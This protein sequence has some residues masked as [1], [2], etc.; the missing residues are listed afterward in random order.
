[1][2]V[3]AAYSA[4]TRTHA[5]QAT[6]VM[7]RSTSCNGSTAP[8]TGCM[9]RPPPGLAVPMSTPD[10]KAT[11]WALRTGENKLTEDKR[12]L[13]NH[14]ARTN[15]R[16]GRAW[17]LK[18]QLRDVYR[19]EHPPGGA[20]QYLRRW[21]TA[22]KRS[23]INAFVALAKRSRST[24]RKSSQRSNWLSNASSRAST[25][26]SDSSTPAATDTTPPNPDLNDLPLSQRTAPQTAHSILFLSNKRSIQYG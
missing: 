24:S 15:C 11:R 16:I 13:V 18:E 7:T 6:S 20:R 9:P 21:I 10:W 3:S 25:P 23:R 19:V 14:I 2:D 4:A 12:A 8:W 26:R 17:T 22:A 1:M 5:P